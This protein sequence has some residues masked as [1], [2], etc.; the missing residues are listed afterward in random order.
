MVVALLPALCAEHYLASVL[1]MSSG[2]VDGV[3]VCGD[4]SVDPTWLGGRR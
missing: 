1:V 3:V 4:G 2:V